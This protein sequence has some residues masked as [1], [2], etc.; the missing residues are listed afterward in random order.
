MKTTNNPK[1]NNRGLLLTFLPAF[2]AFIVT[3]PV[4]NDSE[5]ALATDPSLQATAFIAPLDL[6]KAKVSAKFGQRVHPTTG[7]SVLHTGLDLASRPGEP[8]VAASSG[9]VIKA[10][11]DADRGNHIVIRHDDTFETSYSHLNS[12]AVRPGQLIASGAL[13]GSVGSTGLSSGPHLHY[14]VIKNG[15]AV[16]PAEYLP[17]PLR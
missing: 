5:M 15:K 9:K 4:W 16:D 14:E 13:I 12:I 3:Y 8:V 17:S 10:V 2:L 1:R 7:K 11:F 6:S